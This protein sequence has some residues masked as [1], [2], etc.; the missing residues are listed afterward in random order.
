MS[1][2]DNMKGAI[3]M[4]GSMAGFTFNDV[5]MKALAGDLPLSQAV[6]LRGIITCAL[7]YGLGVALG[8]MNFK[9]GRR[10]WTLVI[11]R[12]IAEAGATYCFL[13]ALFNMPIANV[14]AV[15]QV[16]PLTVTL[17]AWVFISEPLGWRRLT[18]ILGGFVGVLL[19]IQPG[20][21]GFSVWS[22]YALI[23]VVFITFRD[24]IVRKMSPTTPSMTVAFVAAA[25]I[26]LSF[27]AA[28][29]GVEW[30]PITPSSVLVLC[31]AAV[32]VF[33]GYLFAV[34]VMRVGNIGFIAP[35]RYTGLVWALILGLVVFG[36]WP[37][38]LTFIG[39]GIVVA[40]GMFTLFR[41][42]QMARRQA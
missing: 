21:D 37:D 18:A 11:L 9:L 20:G 35:F 31:A 24:L 27:G 38:S 7:L 29:A 5:C 41:E 36:E 4:S 34:M 33:M 2:S 17:A 42:R 10:E 39:A 30:A 16:L 12:S 15:L 3:L 25:F 22:I 13:T 19:I 6:F 40:M 1:L 32:F 26:T 28:S 14:T 8:A 23:A